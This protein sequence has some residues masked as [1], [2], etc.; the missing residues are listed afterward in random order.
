MKKG[1][2]EEEEE[3]DGQKP[4]NQ[5]PCIFGSGGEGQ[6]QKRRRPNKS[7]WWPTLFSETGMG[8]GGLQSGSGSCD[9]FSCCFAGR[10]MGFG[11]SETPVELL[12]QDKCTSPNSFCTSP[13][14]L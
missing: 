2:E 6:K 14:G 4:L 3:K 7:R 8:G 9:F 1:E 11:C 13:P 10:K 12:H 5:L